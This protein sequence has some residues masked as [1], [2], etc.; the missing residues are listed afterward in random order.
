MKKQSLRTLILLLCAIVTISLAN[1][2]VAAQTPMEKLRVAYT[3]IAPTQLNVWTAKEMGY[4]AKH[5]L[6][7]ELVLLVGAPLAITAV[8][9]RNA[10]CI[11]SF[12]RDQQ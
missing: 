12:G 5:G 4:Y 2:Y 7:V 3:V 1:P 6:E 9:R 11:R 8:G 10:D